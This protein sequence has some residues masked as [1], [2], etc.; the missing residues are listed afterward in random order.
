MKYF[1]LALGLVIVLVAVFF[2]PSFVGNVP[3]NTNN[4]TK[5]QTDKE[6]GQWSKATNQAL[7]AQNATSKDNSFSVGGVKD[8]LDSTE[9]MVT[10]GKNYLLTQVDNRLKQLSPFRAK[11]EFMDDI[12]DAERKTLLSELNTEIETFVA[13]KSEINKSATKQDIKNVAEKI[14]T[15]WLKSRQSV[16]V[17]QGQILAAKENQLISDA[18]TASSGIQKRI[19]V[20]KAQGKDAKVYETLLSTYDKKVASAK[21]D[22]ESA[23]EKANA[24]ASASTDAEKE[25]LNKEK[26]LLL[27]SSQENIREA[28]TM[29]KEEARKEFSRKY[30]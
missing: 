2:A 24:V 22:V 1:S 16:A 25:K 10:K 26:A 6:H 28:Y 5:A 19:D 21:H 12:S 3:E 29:L 27:K 14:K 4:I 11:I 20:L 30:K 13:F 23:N 7:Q 8:S 9:V 15:E 18:D 17:A